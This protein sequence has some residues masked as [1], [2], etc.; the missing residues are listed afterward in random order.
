MTGIASIVPSGSSRSA[1]S[2]FSA[3]IWPS[4]CQKR[5]IAP[6]ATAFLRLRQHRD[7]LDLK[8]WDLERRRQRDVREHPLAAHDVEHARTQRVEQVQIIYN[9]NVLDTILGNL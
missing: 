9:F 6:V 8:V 3:A 2:G 7:E 1:A 5:S 4:N